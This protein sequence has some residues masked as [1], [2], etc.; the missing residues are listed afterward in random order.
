MPH[1]AASTAASALAPAAALAVAPAAPGTPTLTDC[2]PALWRVD[3]TQLT[4]VLPRTSGEL[5]KLISTCRDTAKMLISDGQ[6]GFV[7]LPAMLGKDIAIVLEAYTS[8]LTE[9]RKV[10]ATNAIRRLVLAAWKLDTYGAFPNREKLLETYDLFAAAI[11]DLTAAYG[12]RPSQ[13]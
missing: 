8:G 11:A 6:L 7:H 12:A 9:Q 3:A 5:L 13:R 4:E 2:P 10:Q 1:A